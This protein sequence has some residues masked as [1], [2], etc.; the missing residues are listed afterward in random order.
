MPGPGWQIQTRHRVGKEN[1]VVGKPEQWEGPWSESSLQ[2]SVVKCNGLASWRK[3]SQR[4][5]SQDI[6]VESYNL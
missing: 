3:Q 5:H 4:H 6:K 1:T 2:A